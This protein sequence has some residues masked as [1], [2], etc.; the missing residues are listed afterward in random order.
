MGNEEAK[1]V[2]E[3]FRHGDDMD[4]FEKVS[5][6]ACKAVATA[7]RDSEALASPQDR[8]DIVSTVLEKLMKAQT[9]NLQM[10]DN[11]R[12]WVYRVAQRTCSDWLR[13]TK[14]DRV[15]LA[16]PI[17]P[18]KTLPTAS[19]GSEDE[20]S[21]EDL[22]ETDRRLDDL[23]KI[24]HLG[25][26]KTLGE[27]RE[28]LIGRILEASLQYIDLAYRI[29]ETYRKDTRR[30]RKAIGP[31]LMAKRSL[32]ES[33]P[34]IPGAKLPEEEKERIFGPLAAAVYDTL[35]RIDQEI[36]S[37]VFALSHSAEDPDWPLDFNEF[38]G[39]VHKIR[40]RP[41]TLIF[42]IWSKIVKKAG[43]RYADYELMRQYYN[44]L[45]R[46]HSGTDKEYLFRG[47]FEPRALR[48]EAHKRSKMKPFYDRLAEWIYQKARVEN[49]TLDEALEE[50]DSHVPVYHNRGLLVLPLSK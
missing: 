2:F 42:R 15:N 24:D 13:R 17:R 41:A 23:R 48:V 10:I 3:S 31:L 7:A 19:K 50:E 1:R 18:Q 47:L 20:L 43:G 32:R 12:A 45:R 33:A 11:P 25:L 35:E 5:E 49:L 40:L 14:G 26:E 8:E 16:R 38:I 22:A 9:R 30:F 29:R 21:I 6:W 34:R 27:R 44:E 37:I 46:R 36:R 28:Q 4:T 39:E